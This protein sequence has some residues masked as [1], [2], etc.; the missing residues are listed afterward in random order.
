MPFEARE[1]L[2]WSW[3]AATDSNWSKCHDAS[4]ATSQIHRELLQAGLIPDPFTGLHERDVQWVSERDWDYRTSFD[5][6]SRSK[7]DL[8][9]DGLDC[10]AEIY[11]NSVLIHS[12]TNAFHITRLDVSKHV[13]S[14]DNELLIR[15]KSDKRRAKELEAEHRVMKAWNGDPSRVY[16]RKPQFQGGWDWVRRGLLLLVE[17]SF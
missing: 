13:K 9:L 6:P 11:L 1:L 16:L 14:K 10:T 15:F 7:H 4:S 17:C 8:V 12:N 5:A 2:Q 3:K